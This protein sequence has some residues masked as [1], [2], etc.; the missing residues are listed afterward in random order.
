M[1]GEPVA[2]NGGEHTQRDP[3]HNGEYCGQ[4]G[5]FKGGGCALHD[6]LGHFAALTIADAKISLGRFVQEFEVL[7]GNRL[8]EAKL[9]AKTLDVFHGAFLTQHVVNRVTHEG[10]HGK[11]NCAGDDQNQ[12]RLE[13]AF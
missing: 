5:Q 7:H 10:E 13:H 12:N 4:R 1:R 9:R 11:R 8:I 6:D 2:A 3:H